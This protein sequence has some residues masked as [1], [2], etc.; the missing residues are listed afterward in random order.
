VWWIP[1]SGS[2]NRWQRRKHGPPE[3]FQTPRFP[4]LALLPPPKA[5]ITLGIFVADRNTDVA[6]ERVHL[7]APLLRNMSTLLADDEETENFNR[8]NGTTDRSDVAITRY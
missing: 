2:G 8:T 3:K 4:R 6:V 1:E 7:I 5:N